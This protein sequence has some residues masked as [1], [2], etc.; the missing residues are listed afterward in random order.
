MTKKQGKWVS[1]MAGSKYDV[2]LSTVVGIGMAAT[3]LAG[4]TA[5]VLWVKS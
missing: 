2:P 3:A 4:I 5:L 1:E